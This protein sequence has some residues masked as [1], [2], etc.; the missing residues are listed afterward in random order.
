[1]RIAGIEGAFL[2]DAPTYAWDSSGLVAS[3]DLMLLGCTGYYGASAP[4]SSW[5]RLPVP[6]TGLAAAGTPSVGTAAKANSIAIPNGFNPADPASVA[7]ALAALPT[8]GSDTYGSS[9]SGATL[10]GPVLQVDLLETATGPA[11]TVVEYEYALVLPAESFAVATGAVVVGV[12]FTAIT[13]PAAVIS[14][15]GVAPTVLTGASVAVPV[16]GVTVSG[17]TPA[18]AGGASVAAP[19][20]GVDVAGVEPDMVGRERTQIL[21]PSVGV[22]VAGLVPELV[23]GASVAV[24]VA[25]LTVAGMVP[26]IQGSINVAS[27]TYSQSSVYSG[28]TAASNSIM[29][30]GSFANTGAATNSA[31][32]SWVRMD[33]GRSFEVGKVVIGTATSSIPGG[34]NKSYTENR[35]VQ[36]SSDGSIWTTAFNTGTFAANGI[37]TFN[38]SFTARYVRIATAT[39]NFVAIS[40]FYAL[41]PGQSYP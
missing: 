7:A 22:N 19:V 28:T 35:N 37:Y 12:E 30:D 15:A 24:P 14:L 32:P 9:Q 21:I 31:N 25:G 34:W 41:S 33:L 20:A 40:E 8:N 13:P 16:A 2:L 6:S 29:T 10:I 36:Y 27:I 38:T 39:T 17:L 23:T 11:L 26:V 4:A 1:V 3:A 5:L 18:V